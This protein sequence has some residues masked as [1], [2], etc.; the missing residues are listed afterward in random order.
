MHNSVFMSKKK[1]VSTIVSSGLCLG[2]GLCQDSCRKGCITIGQ[3]NGCNIP[4]VEDL[5]CDE[6]GIC[7]KICPGKGLPLEKIATELFSSDETLHDSHL[8]NYFSCYAGFSNNYEVCYHAAS[9]G[10][11]SQF[12][13]YLLEKRIIN[14]AVVV[15]FMKDKPM[16]PRVFIAKNK[17][18]I[19][20]A[21][22]SKYCVVSYENIV[23][24][25]IEN[26]GKYVIVGLP[27]H[28]QAFRNYERIS[29]KLKSRI[30]GHF[31]LYCSATKSLKSQDYILQRYKINYSNILTF[32]YRDEGCMGS[33]I[34]KDNNGKIVKQVEYLSYYLPLRGF[35]NL[36]RCAL[37]IDHYGELADI[38]FG[39][40][41]VGKYKENRI[42]I[43]SLITRNYY[44]NCLINEAVQDGVISIENIDPQLLKSAQQYVYKHKKGPGIVAAFFVRKCFGLRVPKYD[45]TFTSPLKF[46]FIIREL[47]N[48]T[49]RFIGRHQFLWFIIKVLDRNKLN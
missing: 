11:I 35:F 32:S 18:D 21:K 44:W 8:G 15:G 31:S 43:S 9:G 29:K 39:D 37:C 24:E 47:V 48:Y 30:I 19:L 1:N 3:R 34:I 49:C 38:S 42:G 12:L 10:V 26:E 17:K 16:Q 46:K 2:C 33:M 23:S 5:F 20:S 22:S 45:S 36:S 40:L 25:L 13:I 6:C 28:I 41:H 7:C 4:R 27:C 14:G